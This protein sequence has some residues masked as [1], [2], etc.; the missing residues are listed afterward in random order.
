MT[1]LKYVVFCFWIICSMPAMALESSTPSSE[2][3]TEEIV[4]LLR[5]T[6]EIWASQDTQRLKELW[7]LEDEEPIYLAG[8]Q[9]NFWIGWEQINAYL[10]PPKGMKRPT[11]AI[12]VKFYDITVRQLA[13]DLAFAAYWMRTDMKLIFTPEPFGSDNRVTAVFRKTTDGWKY[14]TYAEAFQA[15]NMYIQTLM[16]K[17]VQDDYQEFFDEVTGKEK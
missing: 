15:P 17:D 12:R 4:A 5:E 2:S 6:E 9:P 3:V 8:E 1:S 10:D 16:E 14:V 13:P 11:Q 7:D